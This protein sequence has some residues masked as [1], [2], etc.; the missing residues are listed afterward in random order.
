MFKILLIVKEILEELYKL[1]ILGE[2]LNGMV[3]FQ[4]KVI[5]GDKKIKK[6]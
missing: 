3:S 4:I 6:N 2:N 1:E 5:L